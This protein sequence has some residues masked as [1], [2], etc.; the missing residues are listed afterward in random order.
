MTAEPHEHRPG[1]ADQRAVLATARLILT[2][3]DHGTAHAAAATGTCPA[4]TAV[5]GISFGISLAATLAGEQIGVSQELASAMLAAVDAA[6]GAVR[7]AG[8]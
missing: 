1:L 4:C 5:A 8:N 2:G 6:E 3:A 7:S